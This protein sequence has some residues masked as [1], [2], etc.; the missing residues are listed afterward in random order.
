MAKKLNLNE[1][2]RKQLESVKIGNTLIY[3]G[4]AGGGGYP[5]LFI[6]EREVIKDPEDNQEL[7]DEVKYTPF[8]HKVAI[9]MTAEQL[10]E[11]ITHLKARLAYTLVDKINKL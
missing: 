5:S 7:S 8:R 10:E 4:E 1:D 3:S 2:S 11:L 6:S 9:H